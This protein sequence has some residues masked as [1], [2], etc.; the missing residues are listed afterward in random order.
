M[1]LLIALN[2]LCLLASS[3]AAGLHVST[4]SFRE[5]PADWRG[6]LPDHRA[7]RAAAAP[8][9]ALTLPTT[10]LRDTYADAALKFEA[11]AKTRP[12]TADEAADL[13]GLYV[14]LGEPAKAVEV[15]R[16]SARAHP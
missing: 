12:L 4:E 11:A 5:L 15:L 2:A 1:R 10:P 8:R 14:R 3:A 7:L 13:G 6:F 16:T 9:F